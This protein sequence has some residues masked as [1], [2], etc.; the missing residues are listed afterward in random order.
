VAEFD[1]N[2]H[3]FR[4]D[5]VPETN[6]GSALGR[7]G[8]RFSAIRAVA[9]VADT[10]TV[11]VLS[12][13]S[14]VLSSLTVTTS[15]IFSFLGGSGTRYVKTDNSGVLSGQAI[16]IPVADG[17]TGQTAS[18]TANQLVIGGGGGTSLTVLGGLGTATTVLHGNAGGA[19]SFGAVALAADVSGNL[20]VGNLN[21]G[22]NASAA[23][24]WRGDAT[25][26][27][28]GNN[29]WGLPIEQATLPDATGST[30]NPPEIARDVSTGTQTSNTPKATK[31]VAKFDAATDEHLMWGFLLPANYGS[32]G[33][34]RLKW[35]AATAT[36][37]N[38]IWK[39]GIVPSTDNSTDDS[40]VVFNAADLSS[41]SAA[42]G[43][44]GRTVE[45]T[46]TLTVTNVAATKQ[47]VV[48]I[49]RD[50][51]NGSDTMSGDAI[52]LSARLEYT[53]A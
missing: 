41:A 53:P 9:I 17:G 35:R 47:V 52:L 37:G 10:L 48:F 27:T 36:S 50:A 22:T 29:Y 15:A 42:P 21:S 32:G 51:D 46:I 11:L 1:I 8:R 13:S 31:T 14:L 39:A 28:A 6:E 18:L 45:V 25:W 12:V 19:P 16:P 38:V 4:Q 23:T 24:F 20:P 40:A 7:V 43:T 34:I 49:G 30:N 5:A 26:A 44:L 33:T 3:I 2:H